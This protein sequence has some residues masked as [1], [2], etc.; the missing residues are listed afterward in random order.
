M[1]KFLSMLLAVT[2]IATMFAGFTVWA[3]EAVVKNFIDTDI[4][5][6]KSYISN[7][8][9]TVDDA[10]LN[11]KVAKYEIP[12]GTGS[13]TSR[14][15]PTDEGFIKG[16]TLGSAGVLWGE[17]SIKYEDAFTRVGWEHSQASPPVWINDDGSVMTGGYN[18]HTRSASEPGSDTGYDLELGKWYHIVSA[19]DYTSNTNGTITIWVNGKKIVDAAAAYTRLTG[20]KGLNYVDF[21]YVQALYTASTVYIDNYRAYTTAAIDSHPENSAVSDE[22][23]SDGIGL[24][25]GYI[26]GAENATV[27]TV[28]GALTNG[29]KLAFVKDGT[30]LGAEENVLGA[31]VYAPY[32][33]GK[34]FRTYVIA[35]E[36]TQLITKK[37]VDINFDNWTSYTTNKNIDGSTVANSWTWNDTVTLDT[38]AAKENKSWK[39]TMPGGDR[40]SDKH[41]SYVRTEQENLEDK[42]FD[43]KYVY[44]TEVSLKFDGQF[45]SVGWEHNSAVAPL[46]VDANGHLKQFVK[47]GYNDANSMISG[48]D[49]NYHLELGKW[50]HIVVALDFRN[51]TGSGAPM[52]IWV[53]GK[54]ISNN[55]NKDTALKTGARVRYVDLWFDK[56]TT[57]SSTVWV[58]NYKFYTTTDLD[59]HAA[60]NFNINVADADTSDSITLY[61]K[62][63][64]VLSG[65]TVGAVKAGITTDNTT[66]TVFVKDGVALG[67]NDSAVGSVMT[68][69]SS[70]G[71]GFKQYD[72]IDHLPAEDIIP[73]HVKSITASLPEMNGSHPV[74]KMIDDSIEGD[75]L[76]K[77]SKKYD[78]QPLKVQITLDGVYE[79]EK[80]SIYERFVVDYGT[81]V[82]AYLGKNGV[83]TQVAD[84]VDLRAHLLSGISLGTATLTSVNIPDTIDDKEADTILLVFTGERPET[85]T[86][87]QIYEI[88]AYGYKTGDVADTSFVPEYFYWSATGDVVVSL[89][90]AS[91]EPVE[92]QIFV[93]AYSGDMFMA[94]TTPQ[95]VS[96]EKGIT[97]YTIPASD[98]KADGYTYKAFIWDDI[99]SLKPLPLVGAA[100][101]A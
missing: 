68:V 101:I 35:T 56:P 65:A 10:T 5:N 61:E 52:Y 31:E 44:W 71:I 87:Y 79:I 43:S 97:Q 84:N 41:Y 93:A 94:I 34:G 89:M 81:F 19:L 82:S 40:F 70:N 25:A 20:S 21:R 78:D 38:D 58:D 59:N 39:L 75:N 3:D 92:G 7:G 57:G 100:T 88:E 17:M 2:M 32:A 11:S 47:Q 42:T 77:A 76:Y 22:N 4:D 55:E 54:D 14:Y 27:T 18:I 53:N 29:D 9:T 26:T 6:V 33:N 66:N 15:Q 69:N 85:E 80:L 16:T 8:Y 24:V 46:V 98:I 72:V 73:G 49:L 13:S 74:S 64:T 12:V 37:Y 48:K 90:N 67:D 28:K 86:N 83:F 45:T 63:V 50:Y 95:P 36:D 62:A 30:V 23:S 96:A 99:D 1:K 91:D 51:D 60:S